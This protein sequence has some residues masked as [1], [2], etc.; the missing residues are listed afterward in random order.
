VTWTPAAASPPEQQPDM[1]KIE[2][3]LRT[4][5]HIYRF[6][7]YIRKQMQQPTRVQGKEST[8]GCQYR[9]APDSGAEVNSLS[10]EHL[11]AT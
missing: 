9:G 6:L 2:S 1:S 11:Q 8:V 4:N 10:Y 3:Q 5:S 7:H